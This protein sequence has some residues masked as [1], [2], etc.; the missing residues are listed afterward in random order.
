ML[1]INPAVDKGS[2]LL[3]VKKFTYAT[4]PTAIGYLCGYLRKKYNDD[5]QILDEQIYDLTYERLKLE[6]S[7]LKHPRVVGIPN[8]TVT[9]KRVVE[10]TK[11]IKGINPEITI[12]VGGIH[13]T[14]LPEEILTQSRADIAVRGEGELTLGEIYNCIKDKKSYKEISGISYKENSEI[15]HRP[16]RELIKNI[17]EIPPFPYELFE[18][19][20]KYYSD[21]GTVISSRGCPFDCI[22]CSQRAISGKSYRYHSVARIL[23]EVELLI[24]KYQQK[25][26]WFMDDNFAIDKK[27]LFELLDGII[28]KGFHKKTAFIAQTRGKEINRDIVKKLKECNFISLAFGV[29]T[30]SERLMKLINKSELVQDNIRGIEMTHEAGILTDGSFIFGLPTETRDDRY[31]TLKLACSLPLDGARFNIAVPY[32]GTQL[33]QIAKQENRLNVTQDWQNCCNQHYLQSNT[34]P[35]VPINTHP[36]VLIFDTILANLTFSLKPSTIYKM[37]FKSPLSGGGVISLPK[38]WYLKPALIYSYFSFFCI[39]FNRI[40]TI[41]IAIIFLKKKRKE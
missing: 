8:L 28:S 21:F 10:L 11:I 7:K 24:E 34:L 1:F 27:R 17:D 31:K 6:L 4:F 22:F 26:I 13:P 3:I 12:V 5:P 30:G 19:N 2:Q 29:E 33:Y 40:I 14:V 39:V 41:A 38:R 18:D 16:N 25:K 20:I 36:E 23:G 15:I 35:Y 32:P 9:T 37:L